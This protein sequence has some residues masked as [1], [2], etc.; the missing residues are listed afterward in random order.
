MIFVD[1]RLVPA[2]PSLSSARVRSAETE[3]E[4]HFLGLEKERRQRRFSFDRS[5][6]EAPDLGQ[7]LHSL[8]KGKCAFC[9][10]PVQLW[11]FAPGHLRPTSNARDPFRET[12]DPNHYWWLA[13]RWEN[14]FLVCGMCRQNLGAQFP[15]R[16]DRA[17]YPQTGSALRRERPLLLDPCSDEPEKRLRFDPRTGLVAPKRG[18][19]PRTN[20]AAATIQIF[21]LNR[22]ELVRARL[23]IMQEVT[24]LVKLGFSHLSRGGPD[25]DASSGSGRWLRDV[26]DD[27]LP[28]VAARRAAALATFQS[29]EIDLSEVAGVLRDARL[30]T[31]WL[32]AVQEVMASPV[33]TEARPQPAVPIPLSSA[34]VTRVQISNFRAIRELDLAM[35]REG[36]EPRPHSL[37]EG[38]KHWTVLLGENGTGKSTVVQAVCLAL[39]GEQRARP[40]I[41]DQ[42]EFLRI[43]REGERTP[44]SGSVRV[45]LSTESEPIGFTFTRSAVTWEGNP[46]GSGT[47]LRAY[48]S[49]RLLPRLRARKS[50]GRE[51]VKIENLFNPF[52]PLHNPDRWIA[53]LDRS[54]FDVVAR[55]LKDLLR[56]PDDYGL[57]TRRNG[58]VWIPQPGGPVPLRQLSDGYQ[59]VIALAVDI[60]AGLPPQET[61][62]TTTPGIVLLDE[63]GTH[64]HPRWRME[65]VGSLRRAFGSMQFIATTH[66]PLCLRGVRQGEAVVMQRHGADITAV[67]DLPSP[68]G[69]RVEQLLTSPFFGLH[70]T[71]DPD[72]D[73]KFQEYYDL[74]VKPE[75][76]AAERQRRDELKR[77]LS[78]YRMLGYT[79]RDQLL[80]DVVDRYLAEAR[81]AGTTL[82]ELPEA[83]RREVVGIW[84]R[85]RALREDPR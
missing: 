62:Y 55:A 19:D 27:S 67:T 81:K 18:S 54:Q 33:V 10:S 40:L 78:N 35:H 65:I 29:M 82:N 57:I 42:S 64:L 84:Q 7:A 75:P 47:Y 71:I 1:R 13:Y 44:E 4:E 70:T 21:G 37:S 38:E 68:E 41:A 3:A 6:L 79:R 45:Y 69:L 24:H 66:E 72:V 28:Y 85:V 9:E 34:F 22:D 31:R 63:L 56:I 17:S 15:T 58:K 50:S 14:L 53:R 26:F 76:T 49:T 32:P 74:L 80:Y 61:D 25:A 8:F 51:M 52:V 77:T 48:G 43:A 11:E 46:G 59:T 12:V 16:R 36:G 39:A 83:A 60:M 73:L 23:Q 30:D 5:L 2:P 20:H